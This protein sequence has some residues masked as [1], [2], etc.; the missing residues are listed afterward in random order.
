M[1]VKQPKRIL[2]FDI[3]ATG[4]KAAII[5]DQGRLLSEHL[6][7]PLRKDLIDLAA[8][9]DLVLEFP[10]LLVPILV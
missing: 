4:L 10:V 5:D 1:R 2:S 6:R 8:F 3:G 7:V 9:A